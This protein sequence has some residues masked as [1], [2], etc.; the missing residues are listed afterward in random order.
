MTKGPKNREYKLKLENMRWDNADIRLWNLN[1]CRINNSHMESIIASG[2]TFKYSELV[3]DILKAATA[4]RA[5]FDNAILEN[6]DFTCASLTVANFTEAIIKFTV[7][8]TTKMEGALF[9]DSELIRVRFEMVN[10]T[11]ANFNGA[12]LKEVDFFGANLTRANLTGV[13]IKYCQ[14]HVCIMEGAIL[15]DVDISSFDLEDESIIEM[16]SAA[17]LSNAVWDNVTDEQEKRLFQEKRK[18]DTKLYEL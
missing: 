3:D 15:D 8:D 11:A 14:W 7:F 13:I 16:L 12:V 5:D 9:K 4:D 6:V 18:H 10:L 2:A 1:E 17:D